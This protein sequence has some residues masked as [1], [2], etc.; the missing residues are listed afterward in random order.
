[1]ETL[2]ALL[3]SDGVS[4]VLIVILVFTWRDIRRL[5]KRVE[6]FNT[7]LYHPDGTLVYQSAKDCD[8]QMRICKTDINN[9]GTKVDAN[10]KDLIRLE[11][12]VNGLSNK[13]E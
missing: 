5:S 10:G 2:T 3:I 6:S 13:Q 9:I 1:M 8:D 7:R 12:R 11:E 4:S